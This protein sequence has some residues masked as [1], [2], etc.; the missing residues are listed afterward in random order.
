QP[1]IADVDAHVRQHAQDFR[2]LARERMWRYRLA[3]DQAGVAKGC[4]MA[5]L[6]AVDQHH[7]V[8]AHTQM[9]GDADADHAGA[10]NYGLLCCHVRFPVA[11]QS[12]RFMPDYHTGPV[13]RM[14]PKHARIVHKRYIVTS[15]RVCRSLLMSATFSCWLM[16]RRTFCLLSNTNTALLCETR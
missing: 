9:P 16:S 15:S 6:A 3:L 10:E 8:A 5:R 1:L 11:P 14:L 2:N 4:F 7:I 13:G 12:I